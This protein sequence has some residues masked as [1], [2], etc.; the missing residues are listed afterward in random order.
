MAKLVETFPCVPSTERGRGIL[1]SGDPKSDTILYCNGRSVLIRSLQRPQDVEVYGEHGYAATVARYSPNGE[2]IASADVSGTVRVWGTHNGF[3]LKNEF[4]VLA[5]RIDDLQWSSDCLRIVASGDG[6]GK[7]LVRAFA[8]DLLDSNIFMTQSKLDQFAFVISYMEHS[9]FVNCIRYAP[10]GSK[11]ITVS[12]DKKGMI[13]DGK[14]GD[15]IGELASEDGHKGSIYAVS[16][17]PHSKRVITVSAD[18]SAKIWEISEDGTVGSVIK[19]LTFTESGGA[20][21]MLVGC[22]WQNDHLITVSLGGTMSLF[23]ADD[24]DKPPLLLSGHIKNVTSLAVLGENQKT[25]LSCSYD[26]LIVKWLQGVGYSCKLQMKDNTKIK[27]LAATGSNILLTGFDNKVWRMPLTDNGF[28][29]A[30]HV[31]IGHQPLDISIAIDSPE[32]TAL[33]SFESGVVLLNGLSILSKIDLGYVVAASVISPDG[34]EAIVGGQDGKLHM[35]SV[36]EDN[37]L[38]EEAVLEKHRG[39][40]TVIRY[41]PDL[42]MFASGDANREAVV[43]DRETKQVK[44]NNMLFHTAR[45]NSLAW[46]PNNKMV[47]TGSVDTNVIV[48]EVDKP[49]SSR[50]TVRHAHLGGVNAVAFVDECTV[51]SSGEDAS[52]RMWHIEPQ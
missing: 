21:D 22:L 12:S 27:R 15:K 1:I 32:Y 5:G 46:S 45:I 9:N 8:N 51:A 28:G 24:M 38:K 49:A 50:I 10:D 48:Y 34:K 23:S 4:R 16:W 41:S 3:V 43:W 11:F 31:D 29:D 37:S 44:L 19:T 2:W 36:S 25:I 18:K 40:V 39:A 14:T 6:K 47:A 30:D 13:Y 20:E 35:Y 42:T 7:S 26:G 52:V 17:S 33:V